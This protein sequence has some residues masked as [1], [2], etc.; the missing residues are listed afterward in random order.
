MAS[1]IMT[2]ARYW[3]WD[4]FRPMY[5]GHRVMADEGARKVGAPWPDAKP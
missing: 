4:G 5:S 2:S 1:V 3:I